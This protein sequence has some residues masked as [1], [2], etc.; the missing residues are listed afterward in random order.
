MTTFKDLSK[1]DKLEHIWYY[2]K[3]II[4][5]AVIGI[6]IFTYL[7]ADYINKVDYVFN[8][9]LMAGSVDSAKEKTLEQG[10]TKIM[11]G[12]NPGKKRAG[13]VD[14]QLVLTNGKLSLDMTQTQKFMITLNAGTSDLVIMPE[15]VYQDYKDKQI[16]VDLTK[17]SSFNSKG[18]KVIDNYFISLDK[19][20]KIKAVV[21]S[22]EK[23]YI[24]I[25]ATA[26][27]NEKSLECLKYLLK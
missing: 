2:Y 22:T 6:I 16:F 26:K 9:S 11:I 20:T 14:Y 7:T 23:F 12:G 18:Y 17:L 13:F 5:F 24:A 15:D 27:D 4:I 3:G 10:L 25:P 8:I 19:S 21:K 1:K